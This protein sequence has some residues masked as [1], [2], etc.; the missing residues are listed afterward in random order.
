MTWHIVSDSSCDLYSLP[1]EPRMD[2]TTIPFNINI[3]E[4]VYTDDEAMNAADMLRDNETSPEAACTACPSPQLFY[5]AFSRPGPVI[6]F[7]ISAALSGSFNSACLARDMILEEE[8]DKQIAV[9]DTK[10]TGP[11][12]V[13][14][15]R[16]C[17]E[18]IRS[19]ASFGDVV[20]ALQKAVSQTNIIFALASYHNL[21]KAGRVNRLVGL[22]AGH[23]HLWGIGVGDEHGKIAMRGKAPGEKRMIRFLV[24]EIKKTGLAGRAIVICHCL[25]ERAAQLLRTA[26]LDVFS[27][28][29]VDILPTR[30]LD[31][32]YAERHGLI[33]AY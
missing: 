11:K 9:I 1:E 29:L 31:S 14:L 30:G 27:D 16:A 15:I 32:F 25:N 3:G 7:T 17:R 33:V 6:A 23:L 4:R 24:D 26:L 5:E 2:F 21:I 8:P 10:G 18:M 13:L 12:T 22:M 20:S 19:G 28:T